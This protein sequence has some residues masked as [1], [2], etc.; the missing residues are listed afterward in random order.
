MNKEP[1]TCGAV[2]TSE[3]GTGQTW[4]CD[5]EPGHAG[6]RHGVAGVASWPTHPQHVAELARQALEAELGRF[7]E[8]ILE[9]RRVAGHEPDRFG[10]S[11]LLG[12]ARALIGAA[13]FA[14]LDFASK[15]PEREDLELRSAPD[16]LLRLTM[17]IRRIEARAGQRLPAAQV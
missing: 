3:L 4:T 7:A 9:L 16:A 14:L 15:N 6:D 10:S 17:D 11:D 8:T 1:E 5:K 2:Y 12:A 13:R